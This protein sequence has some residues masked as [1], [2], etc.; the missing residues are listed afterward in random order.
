MLKVALCSNNEMECKKLINY[1]ETW[2]KEKHLTVS[3]MKYDS[4]EKFL[5]H[6]GPEESYD[7]LF[8]SVEQPDLDGAH[9]AG[10]VRRCSQEIQIVLMCTHAE[11]SCKGYQIG[12]LYCLMRPL[13]EEECR[14]CMELM[15]DRYGQVKPRYLL[16][17]N[18]GEI[19][20]VRYDEIYY[21][22]A[23]NHYIV[24]HTSAGP[25]KF[26]KKLGKLIEE[27]PQ[28]VFVEV[29]RSYIVNINRVGKLK[30]A[31]VE[32]E[33]GKTLPISRARAKKVRESYLEYYGE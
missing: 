4:A 5:Y 24:A 20:R 11:D 7:L 30:T 26:R 12:A 15:L 18:G 17:R 28:D 33:N 32:M 23:D 27:L 25:E 22:E 31:R 6:W 16:V 9:V 8:I 14:R 2:E 13:M 3:I 10:I 29:H 21:F 1:I 19:K